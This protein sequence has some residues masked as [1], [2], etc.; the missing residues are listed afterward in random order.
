M[1]LWVSLHENLTLLILFAFL[2]ISLFLYLA[3][4]CEYCNKIIFDAGGLKVTWS[5]P[6]EHIPY[7]AEYTRLPK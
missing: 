7:S 2:Y 4:Y 6:E 1:I 3:K 5:V